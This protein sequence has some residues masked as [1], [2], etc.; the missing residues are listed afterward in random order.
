MVKDPAGRPLLELPALALLL[1]NPLPSLVVKVAEIKRAAAKPSPVV[2]TE[3]SWIKLPL[4]GFW[5]PKTAPV[6]PGSR[7][8]AANSALWQP[9]KATGASISARAD[10]IRTALSVEKA[11]Q[12]TFTQGNERAT[13]RG[14]RGYVLGAILNKDMATE[15]KLLNSLGQ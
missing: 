13:P 4:T 2:P 6:T 12:T 5:P 3:Y 10:V 14:S 15:E 8:G 7:S 1:P 9:V 11:R